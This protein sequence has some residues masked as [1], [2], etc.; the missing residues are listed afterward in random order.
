MAGADLLQSMVNRLADSGVLIPPLPI[1]GTDF[2][3]VQYADDTLLVLEACPHQLLALKGLLQVFA[4]A[5][6][7][8]SESW[9]IMS[10]AGKC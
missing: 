1:P 4:A 3:I 9:K 7:L 8:K 6:G 5:T 10:N 2:P